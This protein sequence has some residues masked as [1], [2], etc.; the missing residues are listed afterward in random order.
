[1]LKA[2][3]MSGWLFLLWLL[4]VFNVFVTLTWYVKI[5]RARGKGFFSILFLLLP[6][7]SP[8]AFLY[9]ALSGD[10]SDE[11]AGSGRVQPSFQNARRLPKL[12]PDEAVCHFFVLE[13]S[14]MSPIRI[15]P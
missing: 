5:C 10:G 7:T 4:P 3:R 2:A 11:E 8:L 13:T 15:V 12:L 6:A 1:M 14:C 9:L